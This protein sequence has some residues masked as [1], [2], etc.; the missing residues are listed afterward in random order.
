MSF[1]ETVRAYLGW[2]PAARHAQV[3]LPVYPEGRIDGVSGGRDGTPGV[4]SGRWS[5][6][7]NQVLVSA[8]ALSAAAAALI[9]LI[10]DRSGYPVVSTAI[11]IGVGSLIGLL[12]GY[13]KRYARVAAGEFAGVHRTGKQHI[14]QQ[15]KAQVFFSMPV[16]IVVLV[17]VVVG[18]ALY[19]MVGQ[20]LAFVLGGSLICWTTYCITLL[21]E[22]Q[23]RAVLIAERGSMYTIET[24]IRGEGEPV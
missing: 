2:C 4:N 10:E 21:W 23:H 6:Y 12:L 14:I 24:A 3:D 13:R 16:Y 19:G 5:R 20:A 15:I 8:V 11:A 22:R 17:A 9:L 18:F 1:V 7:H